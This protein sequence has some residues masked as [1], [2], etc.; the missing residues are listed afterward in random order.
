LAKRSTQKGKTSARGFIGRKVRDLRKGRGLSQGDLA[1]ILDLSQSSLSEVELGQSSLSA[2]QFLQ[3]LKF[4]NVPASH[5]DAAP[6]ASGGAL[7]KALAAHG[8]THLVEDPDL[9]PSEQ[10]ARVDEV[11]RETLIAG[12]NPRAVTALA[13]VIIRNIGQ[14]NLAKLFVRF[15]EFHLEGRYGWLIDNILGAIALTLKDVSPGKQAL[16]L[17]KAASVLRE[18]RDRFCATP[19]AG[20]G[21]GEDYL[22]VPIASAKTKNEVLRNRSELSKTWN[23]L[24]TL[25]V[26]DFAKAI[27][28]S[29]APVTH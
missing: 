11:I 19:A 28:E 24:T 25:Q 10:L 12:E 20:E 3:V 22:G 9:L 26:E 2:E 4:F 27:R 29:H 17:A 15:K 13:P 6:G 18:H 5:F 7:Q 23:I 16:A 8:A 14:I 1:Q 21:P